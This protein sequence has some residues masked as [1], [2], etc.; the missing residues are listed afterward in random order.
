M[1][2]WQ[3]YCQQEKLAVSSRQLS[4]KNKIV[5]LHKERC[6]QSRENAGNVPYASLQKTANC[7]LRLRRIAVIWYLPKP[8]DH[9][10]KNTDNVTVVLKIQSFH[11]I[12]QHL[13]ADTARIRG[14]HTF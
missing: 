11:A 5:G 8:S 3:F 2:E 4:V 10:L 1:L 14:T 9:R 6:R 7:Q 13:R 12:S